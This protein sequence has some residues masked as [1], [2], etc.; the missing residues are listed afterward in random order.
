MAECS[1]AYGGEYVFACQPKA[2]GATKIQVGPSINGCGSSFGEPQPLLLAQ[3]LARFDFGPLEKCL[4]LEWGAH[5]Y[6][7]D[8]R[9]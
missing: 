6:A 9:I 2:I 7:L 1:P 8:G 5:T 3:S 4:S